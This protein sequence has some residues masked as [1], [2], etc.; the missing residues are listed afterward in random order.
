MRMELEGVSYGS[1]SYA[2][3]QEHVTC[4]F[5]YVFQCE[6]K[7]HRQLLEVAFFHSKEVSRFIA[8]VRLSL[9]QGHNFLGQTTRVKFRRMR[10]FE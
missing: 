8:Q 3:T 1:V 6:T 9:V 4:V 5:T 7:C 2:L 10:P